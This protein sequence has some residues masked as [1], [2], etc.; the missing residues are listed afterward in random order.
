MTLTLKKIA[1]LSAGRHHDR[2]GLYIKVAPS[3]S[4][5]WLLRYERAGR[6]RWLGLGPLRDFDLEEARARARKARQLLRDGVDPIEAKRREHAERILEAAR[7][8]TFRT[9]ARQYFDTHQAKWSNPKYRGEFL[10]TMETY[11]F[12][13]FG[14][15]PV[16]MIDTPLVIKVIEPI[17][18]TKNKTAGAIRGRIESVLDWSSVRGLRTGDNPAR[19]KG[20]LAEVLPPKNLIAK[21][22]HH[23]AMPYADVPAF[24]AQLADRQGIGARALEF[25]VLTV[26]RT[27]E[28]VHAERSEIDFENR[29]WTI[30]A[31]RMKGRKEHRVPLANRAVE[32]LR[33]LPVEGDKIFIGSRKGN[34]MGKMV[35]P[36]LVGDDYTVHGFRS[37]FRD[38]AA[39][40]TAFSSEIIEAA[41]AH[42]TGNATELAYKRTDLLEKR[43]KLMEAWAVFCTTPQRDGVV[44]PIRR[45]G[46]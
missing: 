26:S 31:G 6:E 46:V 44:T 2:D 45:G 37:S 20:H 11:V 15:L 28:V 1:K 5:S 42:V 14:E 32:I 22:V 17:W 35:M 18:L 43:R 13:T 27:G 25:L 7:A 24:V 4:G 3:G 8:V 10:T 29:I 38:W 40:S 9:A 19:W 36:D 34:A 39:E 21:P 41:L 12:P 23:E 16:Q 30:P 33:A